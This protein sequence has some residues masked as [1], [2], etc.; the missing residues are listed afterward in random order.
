MKVRIGLLVQIGPEAMADAIDRWAAENTD[1]WLE[2]IG[3]EQFPKQSG[4][5]KYARYV[6]VNNGSDIYLS[7]LLILNGGYLAS[8]EG[9]RPMIIVPHTEHDDRHAQTLAESSN[10]A[11]AYTEDQLHERL[12]EAA[13]GFR[14]VGATMAEKYPA[15]IAAGTLQLQSVLADLERAEALGRTSNVQARWTEAIRRRRSASKESDS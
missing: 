11:V 2:I 13:R 9:H 4:G 15:S 3:L 1:L 12:T 7:D 6:E 8:L 14:T 10:V 5:L